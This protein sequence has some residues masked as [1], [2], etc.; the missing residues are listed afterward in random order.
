M[1]CKSSVDDLVVEEGCMP[2][3]ADEVILTERWKKF[4]MHDLNFATRSQSPEASTGWSAGAGD[5]LEQRGR[6]AG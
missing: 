1:R 3:S 5:M 2:D 6:F 4:T